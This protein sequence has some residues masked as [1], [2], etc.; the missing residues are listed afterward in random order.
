MIQEQDLICWKNGYILEERGHKIRALEVQS[1]P[2]FDCLLE[3]E[4][5]RFRGKCRWLWTDV[6][7]SSS[8][9]WGKAFLSL[10]AQLA[11]C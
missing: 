5:I 9:E 6:S 8:R 7:A 3:T 2:I 1:L 4:V 10:R 11:V